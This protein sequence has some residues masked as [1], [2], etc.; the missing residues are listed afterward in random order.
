MR[1]GNSLMWAPRLAV[2]ISAVRPEAASGINR[3][4]GAIMVLSKPT[5]GGRR[6]R[7]RL[8]LV[9][10]AAVLYAT[11]GVAGAVPARAVAK[12]A[13]LSAPLTAG[14]IDSEANDT[15]GAGLQAEFT[16]P[17]VSFTTNTPS[18]VGFTFTSPAGCSEA[19]DTC[20]SASVELRAPVGNTLTPGTYGNAIEIGTVAPGP[21]M[22]VVVNSRDCDV[23]TGQF[24]IDDST[25]T[26]GMVQMF[27]ARFE[28]HCES[29][30]AEL[31]GAV[32]WASTANFRTR[33]T[34]P[35]SIAFGNQTVGSR[36][37]GQTV[38]I[39][40]NGPSALTLQ[41]NTITGLD[42]GD[43]AISSSTCGDV[44]LAALASCT[45]GV[46]F[47][48]KAS[49]ARSGLLTFVDDLAPGGRDVVLT[50]TGTQATATVSPATLNFGEQR[51]GTF[52]DPLEFTVT[53]TGNAPLVVTSITVGGPNSLPG[54]FFGDENCTLAPVAPAGTCTVRTFFSPDSPV[55][56][57]ATIRV[58][59][60]AAGS[61]Q[62]VSVAGSGTEGYFLAGAEGEVGSFGDADFQGDASD[63]NLNAPIVTAAT[64]PNG[65]GY[66]LLGED[67][68]IFTFG[69][70]QFFGSTG[71]VHLNQPVD[72][73]APTPGGNGYWLVA[74]DGG[75]FTFG[76]APFLGSTGAVRL[77]QP[78]VAMAATPDGKGYWLVASDGGIFTFG[79][80]GFY[81]STGA[82][83]LNRPIVGMAATPDGKGY[84][85]VAS[86]GGIFTFGDA[87]FYGSTGAVHLVQPIVGMAATPDGRGY[88]MVAA[89]GGIFTFGDAPFYGSLGGLGIDDVIA[90]AGT[91]PPVFPVSEEA[92]TSARSLGRDKAAGAL[93]GQ[94]PQQ[95]WPR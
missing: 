9:A 7:I 26:A 69:N 6:A 60:N 57:S 61:P 78:I 24:I 84:W 40:N 79:D 28:Q 34:T 72:G 94:R 3:Q 68:G 15:I 64:T 67:G 17:E 85:L 82:V 48:P 70:A 36:G 81:G 87:A 75:I 54:E 37:P 21:S 8:A 73:M 77:N 4:G 16:A 19:S 30:D 50:G 12:P 14:F 55:A 95:R 59:D 58:N 47:A 41:S 38:T 71:G 39:T 22:T 35:N 52:G 18:D 49:G 25:I 45:I 42:P 92:G 10:A 33:T 23:L 74:S 80:A 88:W 63:T 65:D 91:A 76:D 43:F 83:R 27:S 31:F 29:S 32:S 46:T 1:L 89:D 56:R 93:P 13:T 90:I 51:V 44:V 62:L 5:A 11:V 66:W 20:T 86:D 53:D 2:T